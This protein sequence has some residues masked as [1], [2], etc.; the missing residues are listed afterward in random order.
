MKKEE[1][2]EIKIAFCIA[3]NNYRNAERELWAAEDA[4]Y[5][6]PDSSNFKALSQSCRKAES[7][8][9][10][11]YASYSRALDI[12]DILN[13]CC[14]DRNYEPLKNYLSENS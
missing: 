14:I 12:N 5:K 11:T 7:E 1:L 4:W 2:L 9:D 13:S 10:R 8:R 6:A 3:A